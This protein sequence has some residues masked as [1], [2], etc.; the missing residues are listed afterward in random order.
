M[1]DDLELERSDIRVDCDME[2]DCDIGQ[3][4]TAYI[5][6]W[7]DAAKKFASCT[8][9]TDIDWIN[10]YAKFNPFADTLTMECVVNRGNSMTSFDYTPTPSEAQLIKE[11]ITEQLQ[12]TVGK[13]PKEFCA[14]YYGDGICLEDLS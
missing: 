4:I 6:T 2:V 3:Q 13:T 9:T 7:F 12:N 5:E 14:T 11:L 10:M 8:D 1:K